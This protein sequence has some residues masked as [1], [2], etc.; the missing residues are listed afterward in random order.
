M[1]PIIMRR[2]PLIIG[3]QNGI[4]RLKIRQPLLTMRIWR[5]GTAFKAITT[6]ARHAKLTPA[7]TISSV[8]NMRTFHHVPPRTG[9]ERNGRDAIMQFI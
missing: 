2:L 3:K 6:L 5:A 4:L 8:L 9:W 7:I 1:P